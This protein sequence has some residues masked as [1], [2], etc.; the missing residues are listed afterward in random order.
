MSLKKGKKEIFK[1]SKDI[2]FQP[3]DQPVTFD[4]ST[5][6]LSLSLAQWVMFEIGTQFE[7]LLVS[8]TRSFGRL[9]MQEKKLSNKLHLQEHLQL[10]HQNSNNPCLI[11]DH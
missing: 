2:S 4:I 9:E 10:P 8:S 1:L 3:P 11:R 5:P 7:V 6:P